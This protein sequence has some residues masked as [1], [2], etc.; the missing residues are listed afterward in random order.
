MSASTTNKPQRPTLRHIP[1]SFDTSQH[2]A[3]ALRLIYDLFPEWEHD[4]GEIKFTRFTDGI[5]N[6]VGFA[7]VVTQ[8]LYTHNH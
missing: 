2:Q 3:S 6:I 8:R 7:N 4:D 5:T 1:G